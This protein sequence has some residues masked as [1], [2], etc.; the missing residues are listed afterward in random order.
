M[1]MSM[2]SGRNQ[3]VEVMTGVRRAGS[4]NTMSP[5]LHTECSG[6]RFF[7]SQDTIVAINA[8]KP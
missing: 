7:V 1:D 5:I 6:N 4:D 8:I 2:S 3:E